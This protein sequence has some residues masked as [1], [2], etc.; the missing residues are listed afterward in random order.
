MV[1]TQIPAV[2]PPKASVD[3]ADFWREKQRHLTTHIILHL[4]VV[5]FDGVIF[6]LTSLL[7]LSWLVRRHCPLLVH[8]IAYT[9]HEVRLGVSGAIVSS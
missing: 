8:A 5:L 2:P 9:D 6:P 7:F 3:N 4:V 1:P